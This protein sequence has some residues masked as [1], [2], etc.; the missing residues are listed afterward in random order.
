MKHKGTSNGIASQKALLARRSFL[1]EYSDMLDLKEFEIQGEVDEDY[2][3][4]LARE[5]GAARHAPGDPAVRLHYRRLV[6]EVAIQFEF[7]QRAGIT[8][9]LN[10]DPS[11]YPDLKSL[12]EDVDKNGHVYVWS[13]SSIQEDHPLAARNVVEEHPDWKALF[14][15][16]G[17]HEVFG[18]AIGNSFK[19][20]LGE[21]LAFQSHAQLFS[22]AAWPALTTEFRG[23]LAWLM[24]GPHL[25]DEDKVH[26]SKLPSPSQKAIAVRSEFWRNPTYPWGTSDGK[27]RIRGV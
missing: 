7:L 3:R 10:T 25:S 12:V 20:V 19:T 17:V 2:M 26:W 23:P 5:W 9:E 6:D 11:P 1:A 22:S 16:R 4:A 8:F 13:G 14:V 18:H 15:M 27:W 24:Y 21:D